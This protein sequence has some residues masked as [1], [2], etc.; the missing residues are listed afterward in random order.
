[1]K[2]R[3]DLQNN[4]LISELCSLE[5]K[6]TTATGPFLTYEQTIKMQNKVYPLILD[7]N[8]SISYQTTDFYNVTTEI[9]RLMAKANAPISSYN[10]FKLIEENEKK[11]LLAAGLVTGIFYSVPEKPTAIDLLAMFYGLISTTETTHHYL[12]EQFK[13]SIKLFGLE[14]K[15]DIYSIFSINSKLK[16]QK[17]QYQTDIRMIKNALSHFNFK[18]IKEKNSK[19]SI[20]ITLDSCDNTSKVLTFD[21]FRD[22]YFNSVFLL[23][24]FLA[25]LYWHAAFATLRHNFVKKKNVQSVKK[26][27]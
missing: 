4:I 1:M 26:V 23:N 24:T 6:I 9:A 12:F 13:K 16:N 7:W 14:E 21:E 22:F 8:A 20:V 19:S 25:I 2:A 10:P 5:K 17:G 11:F 18:L 15:Y 3:P 27:I